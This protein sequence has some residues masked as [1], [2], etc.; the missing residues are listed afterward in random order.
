MGPMAMWVHDGSGIMRR[1]CEFP[2]GVPRPYAWPQPTFLGGEP[3]HVKCEA[4]TANKPF[5]GIQST[6]KGIAK[7][8]LA[9][10]MLDMGWKEAE[11]KLLDVGVC[12]KRATFYRA[13]TRARKIVSDRLSPETILRR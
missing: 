13:R 4:A 7:V 10:D 8:L 1:W 6:A 9:Q 5:A 2:W 12:A 3:A 11:T